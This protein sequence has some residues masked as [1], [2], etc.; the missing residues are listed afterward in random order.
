[1]N[2]NRQRVGGTETER[3]NG[4]KE[5]DRFWVGGGEREREVKRE[6]TDEKLPQRT[7]PRDGLR[8]RRRERERER[9]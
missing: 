1:M 4:V 6:R 9:E 3:E 7:Q 8:E 5:K 2:T